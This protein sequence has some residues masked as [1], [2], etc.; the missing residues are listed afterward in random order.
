[1]QPGHDLLFDF[2]SRFPSLP[3]PF[4][5]FG[6]NLARRKVVQSGFSARTPPGKLQDR[7][8]SRM[9]GTRAMG[10]FLFHCLL[11]WLLVC[12]ICGSLTGLIIGLDH[13]IYRPKRLRCG[14]ALS[15]QKV[16]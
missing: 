7:L 3:I 13:W 9:E 15:T 11:W 4:L 5:S 1:M 16:E 8:I 6:M 10:I 2:V 14:K 12:L